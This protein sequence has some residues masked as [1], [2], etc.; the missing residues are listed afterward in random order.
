[1]YL[2]LI[3]KKVLIEL[4]PFIFHMVLVFKWEHYFLKSWKLDNIKW[5]KTIFQM[6]NSK[7]LYR[8]F[9]PNYVWVLSPL[10]SY[11]DRNILYPILYFKIV[12]VL[13]DY[14]CNNNL[15]YIISDMSMLLNKSIY[16][17]NRRLTI[18]LSTQHFYSLKNINFN[19]HLQQI[20]IR[21][22][23]TLGSWK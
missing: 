14:K 20:H 11:Y 21:K 12:A 10:Y 17:S 19:Y 13:L 7:N 16:K 4:Y 2:L 22:L 1:M 6:L 9:P 8:N 3:F 5:S 23:T 18:K 15:R